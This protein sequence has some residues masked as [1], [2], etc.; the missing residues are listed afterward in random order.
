MKRIFKN[1]ALI[2]TCVLMSIG[3]KS[4]EEQ[5]QWVSNDSKFLDPHTYSL[6][7]EIAVSH[8]SLDLNV[9]FTKKIISG[10]AEWQLDR[11]KANINEVVFDTYDLA[12][13]SIILDDGSMALY[14]LREKDATLG[15]ALTIK[16]NNKTQKIKIYYQ[17]SPTAAALQWLEPSQTADKK[18]PF[19]FTQGESIYTRTWI[20]CQD[21]PQV[22]FTYDAKISVPRGLIALMS[23]E[24]PQ[25]IDSSGIYT[26]KMQ[27]PISAY[28]IALAVGNVAYKPLTQN[29]GV[30][31]EPSMLQISYNELTDLHN[32]MAAAE[33]LYGIYAWGRYDVLFLPPAFPFGGMENPRLTFATP[34]ILTGD[35][36][37][38]NLIAHE[39][40]HSWSGNLVTNASWNDFWLNESFTVYFERRIM[41]A[42]EGKDYAAML[43]DLGIQ[44]LKKSVANYTGE[45][46]QYT[47]LALNLNGKDPDL[48]LTDFAYEKGATMLL[49]IE[50]TIGRQALDSFLLG[51]FDY[52]KFQSVH[53]SLFDEYISKT[54]FSKYP[55]L[56]ND[57]L[58]DEWVYEE[59]LPGKLPTIENARFRNVETIADSFLAT[60]NIVKNR[61]ISWSTHEWLHFLRYIQKDLDIQKMGELDNLFHFTNTTNAEI[62]TLWYA[63]AAEKNYTYALPQMERFIQYTGRMKFLEP[64][65][66]ALVN[67]NQLKQHA[68][69][70]FEKYK[71]NYH[72]LAQKSVG[73]ILKQ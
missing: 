29:M 38:I 69:N 2:A 32:M 72:P 12:I 65:Y 62:A 19:L 41:E 35:K 16:I 60:S 51:Y 5:K 8:L 58:F 42:L 7:E 21:A 39:L 55:N 64:I 52:Y 6:P 3:C 36:S 15:S 44:D 17:T 4:I 50:H 24:N 11:K 43:W 25:K 13:D 20:P 68:F 14:K 31:A 70:W 61:T 33:Q 26:F 54:L 1:I 57:I 22:R 47:K 49:L 63:I 71:L 23:A 59:G 10:Y 28:L 66:D 30:Y 67:N 34:T 40:A 56:R 45:K 48:G 18:F 37:L 46:K 9:D 53:T 27:Q 73:G